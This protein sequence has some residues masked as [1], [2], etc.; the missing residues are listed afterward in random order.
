MYKILREV[1]SPPPVPPGV[2]RPIRTPEGLAPPQLLTALPTDTAFSSAGG[3]CP[4]S[5]R[6]WGVMFEALPHAGYAER[7]RRVDGSAD[8]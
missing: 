4:E 3:Q 1:V 7:G 8:G 6:S 2:W 5:F